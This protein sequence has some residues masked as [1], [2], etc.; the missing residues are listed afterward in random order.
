MDKEIANLIFVQIIWKTSNKHFV[1][2]I[3]YN[4]GY[5]TR[6]MSRLCLYKVNAIFKHSASVEI[7]DTSTKK[8]NYVLQ[9]SIIC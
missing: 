4:S 6:N 2:S 7:L 5:N 1:F 8:H 3:W 9:Q